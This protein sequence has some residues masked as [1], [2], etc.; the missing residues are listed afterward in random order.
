M[1]FSNKY[2]LDS[3]DDVYNVIKEEI[4]NHHN[5][6]I[7]NQLKMIK[8]E[9]SRANYSNITIREEA[10]ARCLKSLENIEETLVGVIGNRGYYL[11]TLVEKMNVWFP[12]RKF[13][14]NN[15]DEFESLCNQI[16]DAVDGFGSN[17]FTLYKDIVMTPYY[18]SEIALKRLGTL[19][20]KEL[21]TP[22]EIE[23]FIAKLNNSQKDLIKKAEIYSIAGY[24][25]PD[26]ILMETKNEYIK[27]C[28]NKTFSIKNI[29]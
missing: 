19:Y 9:K 21:L 7:E 29:K 23:R 3:Y 28:K 11:Y 17:S 2:L 24:F 20:N 16:K 12:D 27:L 10:I 1:Q 13:N 15:N 8:I 26:D 4:I 22:N 14:K 18:N 5:T 6:I 25:T